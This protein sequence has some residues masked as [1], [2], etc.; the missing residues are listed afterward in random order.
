MVEDQS[1]D[2][3]GLAFLFIAVLSGLGIY[4]EVIG[5]A[6]HV[7]RTGT[8][9][10]LGLARYGLPAAFAILGGYLI[11][12]RHHCEPARVAIG[13]GLALL[14]A[15]GLFEVVSGRDTLPSP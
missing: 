11:W 4:A 14:A 9:D 2:L 5:P 12:R 7:L 10:V 13:L 3:W 6:G 1:D 8:A 15:A